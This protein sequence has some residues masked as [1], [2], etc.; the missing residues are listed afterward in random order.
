MIIIMENDVI[1]SDAVLKHYGGAEDKKANV[2]IKEQNNEEIAIMQ[3][4]AYHIYLVSCRLN[5]NQKMALKD[6]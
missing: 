3:Y 6:A 4:N 1:S 5:W 2:I